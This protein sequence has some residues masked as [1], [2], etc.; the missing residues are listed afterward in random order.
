M[1]IRL[2]SLTPK[3]KLAAA[4]GLGA[5]MALTM[6]PAGI[7]PLLLLSVPGFT[8]LA[9]AAETKGRAFLTG[10]LFGTGYFM[11]GLYWVSAALFVN[12]P[13]FGKLLPVT[14]LLGPAVLA[15]CYGFIPLLAWRYR[16]SPSAYA[17]AFAAAWSAIEWLRGH[18][19]TGFPWNMPGYAWLH[20]LPVMQTAAY[21]GIYGLTLLTLLWAAAPAA[22]NKKIAAALGA[23]FLLVLALG[24]ARL[25]AHP[26]A[27]KGP[28]IRIVQ[29]NIP[30]VAKWGEDTRWEH[31]KKHAELSRLPSPRPVAAVVWPETAVPADLAQSPDV[32]R[33]IADRM[34]DG[35]PA[36][37]GALRGEGDKF[38]N[39]VDVLQGAGYVQFFYDKHHLVPF[40]EYM[41]FRSVLNLTPLAGTISNIGDFTPGPGPRTLSPPG[42]PPFSPLICYEAIFPGEVADEKDRPAWLVNVTNDAW[43]FNTAGPYQHFEISRLRAVEEGL[44]LAR[45]ANTGISGLI[46]PLGRV[47]ARK[48][49][50]TAGI[51]DARLSA[52]LPMTVYAVYGD[53]V[54]LLMLIAV[55]GF[56]EYLRRRKI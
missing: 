26:L 10:W 1:Q 54:F 5:L 56:S 11:L 50:G 32:M 42:L 7:F 2:E 53:T 33:Y 22:R 40:G 41:P 31:I 52:P 21:A 44:S 36:I 14:A 37:L 28:L 15:L 24:G 16:G 43:Y 35:A 18:A 38:H 46:D 27:D 4:Y 17:L 6:A 55:A 9:R 12:F 3:K 29:A 25:A 48:A 19:L 39:S 45:A 51:V 8:I 47:V 20:A 13:V 49:L 23:S 34:P 30:E